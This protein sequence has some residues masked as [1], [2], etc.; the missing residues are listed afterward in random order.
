[1]E[2]GLG[3]RLNGQITLKSNN[4]ENTAN[5]IDVSAHELSEDE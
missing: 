1:M 2:L 4:L 3:R 5:N